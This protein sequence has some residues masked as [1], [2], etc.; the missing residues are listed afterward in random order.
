MTYART[1]NPTDWMPAVRH[2]RSQNAG[3][4]Y[5]L[6]DGAA[7]V[8]DALMMILLGVEAAPFSSSGLTPMKPHAR[9]RA[10]ETKVSISQKKS[11]QNTLRASRLRT[12][13]SAAI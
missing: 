2:K 6:V 11:P 8:L 12:E 7:I 5:G 13:T 10:Y 4:A 3:V 9:A 1:N